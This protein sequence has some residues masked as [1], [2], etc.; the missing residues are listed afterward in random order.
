MLDIKTRQEYLKKLGFYTGKID[1]IEGPKTKAAYLA[2]QQAYFTRKQD[3]DGKYGG[4]TNIL[5]INAYKVS[6]YTKNFKLHEFKC[7][8][9]GKHCTGYPAELNTQLLR[10][11]QDIRDEFGSTTIS[12]G[13]RCLGHNTKVGG[14]KASRHMFGKACDVITAGCEKLAFRK[15]LMAFWMKLSGARYTY[16]NENGSVPGMGNTVHVDVK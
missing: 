11:L 15:K 1:G 10:N 5:L 13:L 2:L 8:C 9:G 7:K 12:S 4:D 14:A 16:C 6:V 3:I